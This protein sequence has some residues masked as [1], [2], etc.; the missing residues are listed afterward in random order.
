MALM[1]AAYASQATL[2]PPVDASPAQ[3]VAHGLRFER[4]G[5]ATTVEANQTM[6]EAAEA[7]GVAIPSLCRAGVCGTCRTQVLSGDVQCAS[8]MLDEQ[9]RQDGFVLACVTKIKS[10]CTIDA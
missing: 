10:D 1:P 9:D 7:C 5:S 2:P 3:A 4:S 8:Q 6:L